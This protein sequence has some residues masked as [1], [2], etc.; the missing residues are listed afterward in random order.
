MR[1]GAGVGEEELGEDRGL[2]VKLPRWLAVVG[3]VGSTGN[4]AAQASAPT[5]R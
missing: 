4:A 3:N 5:R 2:R 1:S